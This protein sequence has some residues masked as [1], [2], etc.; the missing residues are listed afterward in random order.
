VCYAE[1]GVVGE[2]CVEGRVVLCDGRR[3][4]YTEG[5]VVLC[6]GRREGYAE[7]MV[8]IIRNNFLVVYM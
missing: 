7:G 2:G 4:N 1:E 8:L 5:K 6:D 3:E